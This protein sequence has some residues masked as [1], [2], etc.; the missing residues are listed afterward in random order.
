MAS[1]AEAATYTLSKGTM[2]LVPVTILQNMDNAQQ[3]REDILDV[4][5]SYYPEILSAPTHARS[6]G[7]IVRYVAPPP[8]RVQKT[9]AS[10]THIDSI[11]THIKD[12]RDACAGGALS[13][14][15]GR[16]V[17]NDGIDRALDISSTA[18]LDHITAG[19]QE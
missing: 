3:V 8:A 19:G 13:T 4:L 14:E 18:R 2:K 15:A 10:I 5:A 11:N 9:P 12:E 7:K 16:I 6:D 1:D 17:K